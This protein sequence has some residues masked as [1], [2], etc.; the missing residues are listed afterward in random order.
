MDAVSY[1]VGLMTIAWAIFRGAEEI[2]DAI[3]YRKVDITCAIKDERR[4]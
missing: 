4:A 2:A 1:F 3:R